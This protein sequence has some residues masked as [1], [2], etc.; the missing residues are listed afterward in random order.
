MAPTVSSESVPGGPNQPEQKFLDEK[1]L[2][3]EKETRLEMYIPLKMTK[4]Q[5]R[6]FEV[7][8]NN[9]LREWDEQN[10]DQPIPYEEHLKNRDHLMSK[11]LSQDQMIEYLKWSQEHQ[12]E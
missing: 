9:L 8:S 2:K 11:I 5:V 7:E 1:T 6:H 10:P 3:R 12:P 4:N